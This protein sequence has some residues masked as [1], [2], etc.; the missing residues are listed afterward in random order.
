L[1]LRLGIPESVAGAPLPRRLAWLTGARL[2]FL[3]VP[4]GLIG[5]FFLRSEFS[6]SSF[7]VRLALLVLGAAFAL[8]GV[9]AAMLRSGRYIP[10]LADA[11]LVLDQITW[12][13]VV[14]LS[15]GASSGA[16]SFYGLSCLVGAI[17]TGMRGAAI[18]AVAGGSCFGLLVAGLESG[19]IEPPPDQPA[20]LYALGRDEIVYYVLVNLLVLV[21]V[22][23]LAGYLAERRSSSCARVR[24]SPRRI[25]SFATSFSARREG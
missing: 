15:G 4:L 23:L 19:W 20:S 24:A 12:T 25:D 18:A 8:A 3:L 14:Y 22:T 1:K 16:T 9:Y 7:S 13:A 2:V 10:A 21:V 6:V 17:L 11:Q 5:L